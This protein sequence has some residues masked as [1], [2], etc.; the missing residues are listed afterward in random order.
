MIKDAVFTSGLQRNLCS[1]RQK[2]RAAK[3]LGDVEEQYDMVV[4]DWH[5][6][7]KDEGKTV[8]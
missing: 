2:G 7:Y 8:K 1:G 4:W 6:C 5:S 3:D